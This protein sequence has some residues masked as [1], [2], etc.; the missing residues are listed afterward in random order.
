MTIFGPG[1]SVDTFEVGPGEIV[2]IPPNLLS[3][4]REYR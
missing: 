4:Y 3:L 1:D 2:F